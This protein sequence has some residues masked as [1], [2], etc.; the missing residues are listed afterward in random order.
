MTSLTDEET[1]LRVALFG[2]TIGS[3]FTSQ[4]TLE[5]QPLP[6]RPGELPVSVVTFLI[7]V[8]RYLD[9]SSL[10]E[11]GLILAR[12]FKR[13]NSIRTEMTWLMDMRQLVPWHPKSGAEGDDYEYPTRFLLLIQFGATAHGILS[14]PFR[15]SVPSSV[16][17]LWECPQN[18]TQRYI[19]CVIPNPVKTMKISHHF[20]CF[21]KPAIIWNGFF[22]FY[23]WV[24]CMPFQAMKQPRE[25]LV[26]SISSAN[27]QH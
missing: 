26:V 18:Q 4:P 9:R 16:T 2:D 3:F 7:V 5:G 11:E 17:P 10:R 6:P 20:P 12:G 21:P 19:S 27:I 1:E 15:M 8:P 14:P 22:S 23:F 24:F 25:C 13:I